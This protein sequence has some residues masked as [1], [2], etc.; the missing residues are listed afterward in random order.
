[1]IR[2]PA[3]W[4]TDSYYFALVKYGVI[5]QLQILLPNPASRACFYEKNNL[6]SKT[7]PFARCVMQNVTH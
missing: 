3:Q 5:V 4:Q 7:T 1:M 2:A 6:F